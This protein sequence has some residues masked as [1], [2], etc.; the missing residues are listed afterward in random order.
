M[1]QSNA[2]FSQHLTV[3]LNAAPAQN[4]CSRL[5]CDSSWAQEVDILRLWLVFG[6]IVLQDAGFVAGLLQLAA[7]PSLDFSAAVSL[8]RDA[9][10]ERLGPADSATSD[11]HALE[12]LEWCTWDTEW[13]CQTFVADL[14][15]LLLD[16]GQRAG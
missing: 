5:L 11:L 7:L 6:D 16:D 8:L 13:A 15:R 9:R 1:H 12:K 2:M 4:A 3:M 14:K 10:R